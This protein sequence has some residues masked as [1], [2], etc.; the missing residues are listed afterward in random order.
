MHSIVAIVKDK[1]LIFGG[2]LLV[3]IVL[4]LSIIKPEMKRRNYIDGI[5]AGVYNFLNREDIAALERSDFPVYR[6][7]E[8]PKLA[9]M[10]RLNSL[11]I[12]FDKQQ[13]LPPGTSL[14]RYIYTFSGQKDDGTI[15]VDLEA[16]TPENDAGKA[17]D[18]YISG[19]E[20][21][22]TIY[23]DQKGISKGCSYHMPSLM[24]GC[25]N[26]T[27][28]Q[29][30]QEIFI[31]KSKNC[32]DTVLMPVNNIRI[33]VEGDRIGEKLSQE[34]TPTIQPAS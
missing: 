15:Q 7:S 22:F 14:D 12:K 28:I 20:K 31:M 16:E 11:K 6:G 24:S 13:V 2:L 9:G 17:E 27:G 25:L 21:C 1:R 33:N 26:D 8:A 29:N 32:D 5:P 19:S 23:M 34:P 3:G 30:P 18:S 10:F 4:Y